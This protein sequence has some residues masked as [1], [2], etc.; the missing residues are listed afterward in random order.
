MKKA[1]LEAEVKRLKA[2]NDSYVKDL[3]KYSLMVDRLLAENSK[4][5]DKMWAREKSLIQDIETYVKKLFDARVE[6][7]KLRDTIKILER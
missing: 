3:D 2:R 6:N 5:K 1:E 4:L 7:S